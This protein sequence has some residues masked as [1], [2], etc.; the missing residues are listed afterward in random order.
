LSSAP[1]RSQSRW[2]GRVPV[3][4]R[5]ADRPL[6]ET[7]VA[8]DT[9]GNCRPEVARVRDE[10]APNFRERG[11]LGAAICVVADG[12]VAVDL[13]GGVTR[14]GGAPW[15]ADTLVQ[16]WSCTKGATALCAHILVDR[17]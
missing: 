3:R 12:G 5:G 6:G 10:F 16:V 1:T 11:E 14:E 2:R 4:Y 7:A 13:W 8:L 9:H 15:R 17:G